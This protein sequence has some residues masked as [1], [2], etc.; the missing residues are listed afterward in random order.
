MLRAGTR[1]GDFLTVSLATL[2]VAWVTASLFGWIPYWHLQGGFSGLFC[3]WL[4]FRIGVLITGRR[5][6]A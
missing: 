6:H 2:W 5:P 3:V 4:G 1:Y